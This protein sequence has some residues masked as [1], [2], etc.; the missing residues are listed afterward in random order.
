ME[1]KFGKTASDYATHRQGFPESFFDRLIENQIVNKDNRLLD[2]GTGTG[3][4]ARGFAIK[5]CEVYAVDPSVE[6]LEQARLLAENEGCNPVFSEGTAEK[7]KMSSGKFDVVT[8]GQCWHWFD[9]TKAS[10]EI[11]RVLKPNGLLIIAHFDWLP[12]KG[13]VVAATEALI[14]KHNPAWT[15]GGGTGIYAEWPRDIGEAGFQ[16]IE[17]SSYDVSAIYTPENWR[18]RIRASAGVAASLSESKVEQ[19]DRE[20]AEILA[21]QFPDDKLE[22]PHRVFM[23][24]GRK[25]AGQV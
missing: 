8:A 7:T 25:A 6:L 4:I 13:N 23:V 24:V 5:G 18:G 19:F 22:I 20:H 10:Q 3:T 17:T 21:G 11:K 9:R 15:M 12:L 2:I 1:I 14:Q 16:D